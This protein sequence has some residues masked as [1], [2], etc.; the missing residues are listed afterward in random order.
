MAHNP[1]DLAE[2]ASVIAHDL[3]TP[4]TATRG[5]IEALQALGPLTDKQQDYSERALA[6]LEKMNTLVNRLVEWAWIDADPPLDRQDCDLRGLIHSAVRLMESTAAERSIQIDVQL[7]DN[8]G[9]IQAEHRRLDHVMTNL[10]SNAVKY[11]REQGSVT[12]TADGNDDY[13]RVSVSDTGAGI[14][15]EHQG[16]VF[17]RFYRA[18]ADEAVRRVEG[19][20]LGLAIVKSVIEQHDGQ[21]WLESAIGQ[22]STF[23]F[24]LPRRADV[25]ERRAVSGEASY[26]VLDQAE[27]YDY[28]VP[29]RANEESDSVD[30]DIQEPSEIDKSAADRDETTA[31]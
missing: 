31:L 22:G 25:R 16:R 13:V 12:V 21:I 26:S 5:L 28:I 1:K 10:L 30:D 7:P 27:G 11:N 24:T 3:K 23:T 18:T 8:L 15:P 20:G 4:I 6:N 14:A 19:N 9:L 2:I 29:E 17:E